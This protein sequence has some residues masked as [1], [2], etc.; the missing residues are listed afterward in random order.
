MRLEKEKEDIIAVYFLESGKVKDTGTYQSVKKTHETTNHKSKSGLIHAYRNAEMLTAE[1]RKNIKE[2]VSNCKVCVKY[3]KSLVKPKVALPKVT[4]FN[5][6]VTVDLKQ[7]G[8]NYILWIVDSLTRFIQSK[9]IGNK[10]AETI[11]E[12]LD[13]AWNHRFGFPS[14]GFW[15]DNGGEFSNDL[16]QE[17]ADKMGIQFKF[18]PSYSPWSNAINERNHA[19]ADI[20]VSKILET[21]GGRLTDKVVSSAAWTHNTNVNV[22]GSSPLQLATGKAVSIPGL[23][24]ANLATESGFES[25]FIQNIMEWRMTGIK[26]FRKA[27]YGKKLNECQ[28]QRVRSYQHLLPYTEGD[29]VFYQKKDE[30]KWN[31]PVE[32]F[33]QRGGSVWIFVMGEMR[34]VAACR[35]QPYELLGRSAE[36]SEK[37]EKELGEDKKGSKNVEKELELEKSEKL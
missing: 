10:K 17:V 25:G 31:G 20:T 9:V 4:D 19:S 27:E 11:V 15:S 2:V 22:H 35:V 8:K 28:R 3:R 29:R 14:V 23:S 5:E 30:K 24:S 16:V 37:L 1:A 26:E 6:V 36:E 13:E 33:A 18:G 7:M 32:V 34:K 12:S 21:H